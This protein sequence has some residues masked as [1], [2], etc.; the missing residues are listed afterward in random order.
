MDLRSEAGFWTIH[1]LAEGLFVVRFECDTPGNDNTLITP[2]DSPA[3]CAESPW[4]VASDACGQ[5]CVFW[6]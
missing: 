3:S 2:Q 5:E 1:D 6:H 4:E